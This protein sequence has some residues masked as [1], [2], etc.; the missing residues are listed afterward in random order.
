MN[1]IYATELM[2]LLL[3]RGRSANLLKFLWLLSVFQFC[4]CISTRQSLILHIQK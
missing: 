1:L 4:V 3:Y 2:E